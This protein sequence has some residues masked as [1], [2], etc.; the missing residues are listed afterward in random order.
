MAHI[1]LSPREAFFVTAILAAWSAGVTA[2]FW[3]WFFRVLHRQLPGRVLVWVAASAA[4]SPAMNAAFF[5][6]S[7]AATHAREFA[8]AVIDFDRAGGVFHLQA[9]QGTADRVNFSTNE[10][11]VAAVHISAVGHAV[12]ETIPFRPQ[13]VGRLRTLNASEPREFLE[14]LIFRCL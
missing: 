4:L 12:F 3:T 8:Q 9:L 1:N 7:S 14:Q 13:V 5:A 10:H 11:L 2:P 6:Y